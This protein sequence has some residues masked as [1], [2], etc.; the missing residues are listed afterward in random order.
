MSAEESISKN[1]EVAMEL[2]TELYYGPKRSS[3]LVKMIMQRLKVSEPTVYATLQELVAKGALE[4]QERSRRRVIYRLTDEGRRLMDKEHFEVINSLLSRLGNQG[5]RREIMVELLIL[6]LLE[7]LPEEMR[8]SIKM[9]ALRSSTAIE[10]ED[11][12]KRLVRMAS[13]LFI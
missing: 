10:F 11:M 13:A 2:L 1:P 7:E 5:R 3:R 9:E 6:D 4:K 12:R 8:R